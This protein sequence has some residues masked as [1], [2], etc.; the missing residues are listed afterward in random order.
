[1]PPTTV[2]PLPAL[3]AALAA[4]IVAVIAWMSAR[5]AQQKT[6]ANQSELQRYQK[7]LARLQSELNERRDDRNARRDY[8]Y[9]ALKRLYA[10][11]S[12][13]TFQLAEQAVAAMERIE[14]L[15]ISSMQ[16]RLGEA[17][18]S[19][20]T[21]DRFR[22]Y[23][24]S[25]E[26]RLL[27]PLATLRLLEQRLTHLDLSLDPEFRLIYLLAQKA[28]R[29]L[30]ADFDLS[31][32]GPSPLRYDPHAAD[33]ELLR[34]HSPH[35][36]WQQGVPLG[37]L[38]NAIEALLVRDA[39]EPR[40]VIS[41]LEFE[42]VRK[43]PSSP[44]GQALDRMGYLVVGFDPWHRP[45]LWRVLL[46]SACIYRGIGLLSE[47][48][49]AGLAAVRPDDLI[50]VPDE[51]LK[52]FIWARPGDEESMRQV[53][54]D[55]SAVREHTRKQLDEPLS[56]AMKGLVQAQQRAQAESK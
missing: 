36:Y 8:E 31:R 21:A 25:T 46:A 24:L 50:E 35:I 18:D 45:V 16:G 39:N 15:A 47:R 48:D 5:S 6:F 29:T 54:A 42:A 41:F 37:I 27:A 26:Y 55:W 22:Y 32:A 20:L 52:R 9:E 51:F 23:R 53:E 10:E 1:M 2:S 33:A 19:W 40:R 44:A 14:S 43:A 3:I 17:V 12:P 38:D 49:S 4:V 28:R 34:V 30:A 13:L 56:R 7:D 11:C